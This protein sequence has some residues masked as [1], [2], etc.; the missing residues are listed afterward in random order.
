[1]IAIQQVSRN[2][3]DIWDG[4]KSVGQV[5]IA[6]TPECNVLPLGNRAPIR[7]K[8]PIHVD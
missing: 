7:Q 5:T 2:A 3:E 6:Y 1:M 4:R 8:C